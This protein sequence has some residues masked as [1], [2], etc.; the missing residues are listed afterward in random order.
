MAWGGHP[1]PLIISREGHCARHHLI[2]DQ[3]RQL[4]ECH[5]PLFQIIEL[6]VNGG[7]TTVLPVV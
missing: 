7:E 4:V 5:L 6:V 3:L 1:H 2:G